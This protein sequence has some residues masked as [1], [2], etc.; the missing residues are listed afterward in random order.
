MF[1]CSREISNICTA[2]LSVQDK[3]MVVKK[4]TQGQKNKYV[5]YPDLISKSKPI[6][7]GVG[8]LLLQPITCLPDNQPAI[9]TM[10]IAPEF[11]EW[12]RSVTPVVQMSDTKNSSGKSIINEIQR[13]GG[14]I[15]YMKRYALAAMLAWATGDYD[16]D[17]SVIEEEDKRTK[18]MRESFDALTENNEISHKVMAGLEIMS[19]H[20]NKRKYYSIVKDIIIPKSE[21]DVKAALNMLEGTIRELS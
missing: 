11:A 18:F 10:L 16:F 8:I 12:I 19:S 7:S 14:G 1:D 3:F 2:L 13:V 15:S 21:E 5:T 6:L 20:E 4:T 17:E 9:T